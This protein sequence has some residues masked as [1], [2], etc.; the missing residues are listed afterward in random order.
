MEKIIVL[1]FGVMGD[2]RTYDYAVVLRA[3]L[4]SDFMTASRQASCLPSSILPSGTLPHHF[5][6]RN[7]LAS[8]TLK[9]SISGPIKKA[10]MIV[11][12]P[13]S[14]VTSSHV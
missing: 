14:P 5:P 12:I 1:D 4:T 7:G 6:Y 10:V 2:G 8:F 13:T 3:V 9:K 11:P